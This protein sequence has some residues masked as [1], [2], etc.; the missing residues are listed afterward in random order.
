MTT[1]TKE[2]EQEQIS[3]TFAVKG[4]TCASCVRHVEGAL[5]KVDGV[6]TADVNLATERVTISVQ[7]DV[8]VR[9][10]RSSVQASGYELT[11]QIDEASMLVGTAITSVT[12]ME[13]AGRALLGM[14][15]GAA[16]VKGGHMEGAELVDVL[17][18]SCCPGGSSGGAE[19][20]P[21]EEVTFRY[22]R[23]EWEYYRTAAKGGQAGGVNAAH[24]DLKINTG[25]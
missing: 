19:T 13:E 9:E 25:G 8:T 4:M 2:H 23:V 11:R 16:L 24:W 20:L 17:V 3:Q 1:E 10:L 18:T 5:L 22:G 21:I 12:Q 6:E 7:P 14:G 15:A